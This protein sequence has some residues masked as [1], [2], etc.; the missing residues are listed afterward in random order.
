MFNLKEF[1][2]RSWKKNK[3]E[4]L[5]KKLSNIFSVLFELFFNAIEVI[6]QHVFLVK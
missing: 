6:V 3:E 2:R 5:Q 1:S 4:V